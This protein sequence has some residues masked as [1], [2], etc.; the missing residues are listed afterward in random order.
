MI[1]WEDRFALGSRVLRPASS[2]DPAAQLVLD[3]DANDFV[4][5]RLRAE[6][7]R[8]RAARIEPARPAGDDARDQRVGFAANARGH[9]VAG[10]P[11][12]GGDLLGDG[13][14]HAGHGEV[15]ARPE[16]IAFKPGGVDE[17]AG[18]GARAGIPTSDAVVDGQHRLLAVE[19]LADDRG[20]EAGGGLIRPSGPYHDVRQPDPD[21]VEEAAAG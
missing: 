5:R 11:A 15:D 6:A 17:K 9:L 14:A 10:N 8:A 3:M 19:R 16:R 4:E 20:K 1:R 7:E 2:G 12:Q 21:T 18:G 13:A